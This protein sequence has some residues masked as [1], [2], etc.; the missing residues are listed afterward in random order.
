LKERRQLTSIVV[1]HDMRLVEAIADRIVFL[2]RAKVIFEGT[3]EQMERSQVPLVQEFLRLDLVD[4]SSL[5]RVARPSLR[6]AK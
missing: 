4:F 2:D 5:A 6:T 1:T 3:R